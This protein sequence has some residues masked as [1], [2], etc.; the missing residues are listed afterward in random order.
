MELRTPLP[1]LM[2]RFERKERPA[3]GQPVQRSAESYIQ[4]RG[5]R[6]TY[7]WR[8]FQRKGY[9]RSRAGS[10]QGKIVLTYPPRFYVRYPPEGLFR[11]Q[12]RICF[13][14]RPRGWYAVHWRILPK[15]LDSGVM[16]L[17]RILHECVRLS[18]KTG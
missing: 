6:L 7:G 18:K 11:H 8:G 3:T 13:T 15:D 12:H 5:W 2:K 9:Y 14:K 16:A 17:E 4:E 10:F 1:V